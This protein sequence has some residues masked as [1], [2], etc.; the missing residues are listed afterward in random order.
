MKHVFEM[1]IKVERER[2]REREQGE[3]RMCVGGCV[4][5]KSGCRYIE[6]ERK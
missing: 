1:Y 2:E 4:L 6:G 3:L 5:E